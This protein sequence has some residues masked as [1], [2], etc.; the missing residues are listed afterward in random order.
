[1]T[2]VYL[3]LARRAAKRRIREAV[4]LRRAVDHARSERNRRDA[5]ERQPNNAR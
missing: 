3:T 4:R 5:T 2:A 1:M